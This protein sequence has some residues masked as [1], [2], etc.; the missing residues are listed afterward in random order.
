M[1]NHQRHRGQHSDDIHLFNDKWVT[2]LRQAVRDFSYLL[3]LGYPD[4]ASLKLVGDKFRLSKRQRKAV[5]RAGC[6]NQSIWLRN[7]KEKPSTYLKNKSVAI[8]TYNIL[9]S[10]ESLLSDGI[11]LICRDG[12]FRDM[13]S[14]HGTYRKVEETIPAIELIGQALEELQ[15]KETKWYL[16]SPISNSGRL[17]KLILDTAAQKKWRWDAELVINPDKN[18]AISPAIAISSD[19]WV[20]EQA[21]SWFNLLAYLIK[22]KKNEANIKQLK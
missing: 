1:P 12:C 20:I 17:K 11:L 19:S 10:T 18:L 16:D 5:M 14:L 21:N 22:E 2:I 9:I 8:D 4:H 15:V 13:A 3:T 7:E 6:T